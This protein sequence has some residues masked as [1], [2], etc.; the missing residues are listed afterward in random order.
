MLVRKHDIVFRRRLYENAL[1][2]I[3]MDA[4][5]DKVERLEVENRLA[6]SWLTDVDVIAVSDQVEFSHAR[7]WTTHPHTPHLHHL[8]FTAT[9]EHSK[10]ATLHT[11]GLLGYDGS[12]NAR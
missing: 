8:D 11:A 9:Q 1:G 10:Q 12:T 2:E 5:A 4:G 6:R 3:N 7:I